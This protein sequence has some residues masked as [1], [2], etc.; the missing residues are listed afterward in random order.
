[1]PE[2]VAVLLVHVINPYGAAWLRRFNGRNVDLN[3]NYRTAEQFAP[4]RIE[5]WEELDAVLNQRGPEGIAFKAKVNL[6]I[7]RFGL[8]R[9]RAEVG[10]GQTVNPRGLFWAG[11]EVEP[12]L[13]ALAEFYRRHCVRAST[14]AV[15]DVHTG[16]GKWGEDTL[17]V[18]KESPVLKTAFGERVQGL[19][20]SGIAYEAPGSQECMYRDIFCE[21]EVS[22]ITQE[23]GTYGALE[24]LDALRSENLYENRSAGSVN[25]L[26]TS[27]KNLRRVF[28]PKYSDWRLPVLERGAEVMDQALLLLSQA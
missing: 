3:R 5:H 17:L 15:I 19:K 13:I 26:A 1:M 16:L 21:S 27:K 11:T 6:L 18:E 20:E 2:G 9:L 25:V 8:D 14:V 7:A 28:D 4:S 23:F 24:V 10:G 22:F 12:E